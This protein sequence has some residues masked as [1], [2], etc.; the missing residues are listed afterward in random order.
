MEK[1]IVRSNAFFHRTLAGSGILSLLVFGIAA[2]DDHSDMGGKC[3][4]TVV[5]QTAFP[6]ADKPGH[7]I[8]VG[9]SKGT[10]VNTG[11]KPWL[12]GSKVAVTW[13][14]DMV[15][16][17]GTIEGYSTYTLGKDTESSHWVGK[18]TT[19]MA[20][21]GKTPLTTS[22]GTWQ[23]VGGTGAWAGASGSGTWKGTVI[24]PTQ[25]ASEWTG[26]KQKATALR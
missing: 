12:P 24:S 18:T 9:S 25:T 7:L 14:L 10:N 11:K 6:I 19:V 23:T 17:T 21:D 20:T 26:H 16:G 13:V 22:V 8:V 3:T 15:N 1:S 5:K 4:T 2:A